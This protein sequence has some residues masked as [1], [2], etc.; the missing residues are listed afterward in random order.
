MVGINDTTE[1][2]RLREENLAL[3]AGIEGDLDNFEEP[4]QCYVETVD[5]TVLVDHSDRSVF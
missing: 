4:T 1:L 5:P 3:R 2:E